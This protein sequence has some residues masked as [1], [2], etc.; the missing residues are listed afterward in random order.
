M[1]LSSLFRY[2]MNDESVKS[3]RSKQSL[4]GSYD[5]IEFI[6]DLSIVLDI[7]AICLKGDCILLFA[8]Q[9]L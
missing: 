1:I 3:L 9:S 2:L 8:F 6:L 7:Y 4:N 5:K